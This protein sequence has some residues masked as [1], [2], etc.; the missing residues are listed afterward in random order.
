MRKIFYALLFLLLISVFIPSVRAQNS[1]QSLRAQVTEIVDQQEEV[2]EDSSVSIKQHLRLE[3]L[4]GERKGEKIEVNNINNLDVVSADVYKI[5]DKV[6]LMESVD[7]DGES[8]FQVIDRV[9]TG[10][11]WWLALLFALIVIVV[12]KFKGLKSLVGLFLSFV[13]IMKFIIPQ[14]LAGSN[15]LLIGI[16]GAFIILL[17]LIYITEGFNKISH[18]ST[19][20]IFLSLLITGCLA[21][22]FTNISKLT[23]GG[24]DE[25]LYLIGVGEKIINLKGLLLTGIIIGALGVLDDVVVSQV[26]LVREIKIANS[27]L[28]NKQVYKK[29]MKVGITHIGA[30]TNTLFLAYVGVSLPLLL[31]F[32]VNNPPFI[33]VSDVFNNEL[34]ATEIVR[35][36]TGSIGLVLAAPI[37]TLLA[38]RFIKK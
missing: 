24:M 37:A 23:G 27:E 18:I 25:V 6:I 32:S 19:I 20:A 38:V 4:K 5:G 26:S 15:P 31:L 8:N 35:T 1:G 36:L 10:S 29:A 9:R 3:V 11:L 14:I 13:V 34:I 12:G 2:R 28:S 16:I 21:I 17:L 22:F 30:M 7:I 33:S